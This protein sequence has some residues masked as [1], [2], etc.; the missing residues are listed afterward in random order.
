MTTNNKQLALVTDFDGTIT[1]D[2]FFQYVK[3][4]F[5]DDSV[6]VPWGHYLEGNL[7]HF[8]ALKQIYG[9]LRA[10]E[11]EIINL[12]KKVSV[13]KW[14]IPT[15]KLLHEA[16]IPIYIASAGCDYYINLL[17]GK[18]IEQYGAKLITN[19]SSYSQAGGLLM[20][21]PAKDSPFYDEGVGISKKKIV[22]TLHKD[23]K[24][25][26]FAGDGPPDIEPA[27]VADVVFARHILL[28][29]C[30]GEG[31]KTED[32]NGYKDIYN[33]FESELTK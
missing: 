10:S 20:E 31:V 33:Y 26:I 30:I 8:D 7:S 2:D 6:L 23:G 11:G 28:E 14:V 18:E 3:D 22:E 21:R 25:V 27:R 17:L 4:A 15:F 29:K 32:F 16:K 9:T 5:F 24:H 1:D 12:V 13:D 19:S